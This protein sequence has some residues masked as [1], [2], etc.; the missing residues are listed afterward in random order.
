MGSQRQLMVRREDDQIVFASER[1][2]RVEG[3]ERVQN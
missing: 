2:L 1:G 3:E